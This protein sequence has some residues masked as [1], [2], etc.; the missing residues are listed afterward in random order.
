[1][2]GRRDEGD[3]RVKEFVPKLGLLWLFYCVCEN[4]QNLSLYSLTFLWRPFHMSW[5][6]NRDQRTTCGHQ[7]LP[8]TMWDLVIT[9]RLSAL[10]TSTVA[11]DLFCQSSTTCCNESFHLISV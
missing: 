1:M 8:S 11:A 7:V 4:F 9:L 10:V 3:E 5:Y 6:M 2:R